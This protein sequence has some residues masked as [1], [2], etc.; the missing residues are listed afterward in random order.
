MRLWQYG[1][2]AAAVLQFGVPRFQITT[3]DTSLVLYYHAFRQL[4][5]LGFVVTLTRASAAL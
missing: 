1:A 4:M 3:F 5:T 2:A